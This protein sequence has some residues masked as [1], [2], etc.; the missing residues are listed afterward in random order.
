MHDRSHTV[1]NLEVHLENLQYVYFKST[2]NNDDVRNKSQATKLTEFFKLCKSNDAIAT[3][4]F[5]HE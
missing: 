4:I 5:Y 2:D 3:S 1:L